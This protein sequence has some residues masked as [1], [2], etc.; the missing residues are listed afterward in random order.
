MKNVQD[1]RR[2]IAAAFFSI[3]S[4]T[5]LPSAYEQ[6]LAEQY[7]E[8]SLTITQSIRLLEKYHHHATARL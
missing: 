4:V 6:L 7:I 1:E 8:G 2:I 5:I 3:N